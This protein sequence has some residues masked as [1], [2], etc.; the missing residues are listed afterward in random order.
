[1]SY[2]ILYNEAALRSLKRQQLVQLCKKYGLRASGKVSRVWVMALP[3]VECQ[4]DPVRGAECRADFQIA[5][6]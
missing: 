4:V 2:D 3:R 1:M 5:R 6:M